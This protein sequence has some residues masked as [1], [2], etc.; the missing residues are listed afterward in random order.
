MHGKRGRRLFQTTGATSSI[1]LLILLFISVTFSLGATQ[2][3]YADEILLLDNETVVDCYDDGEC[4]EPGEMPAPNKNAID[5][6]LFS[7]PKKIFSLKEMK[8]RHTTGGPSPTP[9]GAS[10]LGLSLTV[11]T[12]SENGTST[13]DF[14]H[15]S[16][17]TDGFTGQALM[18]L[19]ANG[20]GGQDQE[21]N[22]F[23][24][25]Y[26]KRNPYVYAPNCY[27]YDVGCCQVTLDCGK[28]YCYSAPNFLRLPEMSC[29]KLNYVLRCRDLGEAQWHDDMMCDYPSGVC[30]DPDLIKLSSFT[31][32]PKNRAVLLTWETES[33]VNNV[34]FNLYRSETIDGEKELISDALIPASG[35][36]TAGAVYE[37]RDSGLQNRKTYYYFLEDVDTAGLATLHGPVEATPRFI[38]W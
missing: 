28:Q 29:K 5:P 6:V 32:Q 8:Y 4:Y 16:M 1:K 27:N 20:T 31:A 26:N 10:S 17:P 22:T 3:S 19:P 24:L 38:L 25:T 23:K 13:E 7:A 18:L 30:Y 12:E 21:G 15:L 34:G 14:Q 36:P 2:N 35:D 11:T 9:I 37:F 33:E